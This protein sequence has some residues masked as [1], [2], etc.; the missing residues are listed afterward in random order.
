MA[1]VETL[2][3][4]SD[5]QKKRRRN[6]V[7]SIIIGVVLLHVGAGVVAGIFVVAK[8][9]FPPP[10]NFVVKKDVRLPAKKREH[11]MNMASLDA[12]APKPTF[13]DRMQSTRPT[14]FSLPEMPQIPLDQALPLDPSQLIADN[15]SSLA[16]ADGIGTGGA[17]SAGSAGFGGKG[18]SFL[19][20]ESTGQRILLAFDVAKSIISK[21]QKTGT[22]FSKVKSE[23]LELIT[24][25]PITSRFGI[26]QFV[27]HYKP[28]KMELVP[29][30][31][32]NRDEAKL[33]V[34][35]EWNES[36]TMTPPRKGVISSPNG[37]VGVLELAAKMQPDIVF[38]ISDGGF[39]SSIH[40]SGIPWDEV[41]RAAEAIKNPDGDPAKINFI[42]FQPEEEDVKEL[43]RISAR[44]G[45]KTV[46]IKN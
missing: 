26:V 23:T 38:I 14:A 3:S 44:S 15:V 20:V 35:N 39:E 27:R 7:I 5:I 19:G 12:A 33:W 42:S 16:A 24:K 6:M 9:I 31:Q 10:A 8:Y 46:E 17:G 29:A 37:F 43:K 40:T 28:F 41:R 32:G 4:E 13:S 1:S 2:L 36:G 30:S 34:E 18:I 11:K 25:L 21:A 22:P 45:G